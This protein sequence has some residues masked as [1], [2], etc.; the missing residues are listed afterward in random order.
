MACDV[1][2]EKR[3]V[4]RN[5]RMPGAA[6]EGKTET[7]AAKPGLVPQQRLDLCEIIGYGE[8]AWYSPGPK[9]YN[10]PYCDLQLMEE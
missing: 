6:F 1:C 2:A 9:A 5:S 10:V 7:L 3:P 4:Q 8:P